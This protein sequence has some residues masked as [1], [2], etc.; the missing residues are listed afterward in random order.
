MEQNLKDNQILKG[1]VINF[2]NQNKVKTYV[3]V[4][5]LILATTIFTFTK[6]QKEQKNILVAEKYVQA[7]IQ[8]ASN[9]R[10]NARK[11]YEEI[12]LSKNEFYSIL[13]LNTIIEKNLIND[14]NEIIKYFDLL[15]KLISTKDQQDLITLKKALYLIK[16]SDIEKGNNLLKKLIDKNSTLKPIVQELLGK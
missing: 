7:E 12:I 3:F 15:G 2:Y 1:R 6:Y 16:E 8:L 5:I 13:A 9:K 4:F 11:L 10:D 14:K